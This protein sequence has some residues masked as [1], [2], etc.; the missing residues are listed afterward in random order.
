[1]RKEV[2]NFIGIML[3]MVFSFFIQVMLRCIAIAIIWNLV[4]IK[5]FKVPSL[6]KLDILL[7]VFAWAL[8]STKV[9]LK[10][11]KK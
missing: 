10:F 5:I 4:V 6:T 8:I 9:S 3:S 2:E 11:K 1:M 7:I